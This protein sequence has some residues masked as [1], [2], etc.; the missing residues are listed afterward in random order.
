MLRSS[1][2]A[3][4]AGDYT[5]SPARSW[6]S[7][8]LGMGAKKRATTP[9]EE[10]ADLERSMRGMSAGSPGGATKKALDPAK[11]KKLAELRALVDESLES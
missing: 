4:R 3:V 8:V 11:A 7:R 9:D 2:D 10:L 5:L 1:P 6:L